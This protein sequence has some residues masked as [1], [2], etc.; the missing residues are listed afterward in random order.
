MSF[1]EIF[2]SDWVRLVFIPLFIV[3]A[4]IVDV[5]LGTLRIIFVSKGMKYLAPALGFV[6]VIIWLFAIGQIMQNLSN[7][8]NYI[9]YGLGF[10]LGN[11]LGIRIEEKLAMGYVML[12]VI[13]RKSA[14]ELK[15]YFMSSGYKFT[16][17]DA[18]SDEGAVNVIYMSVKRKNLHEMITNIKRYNPQAFYTIED[19]KTVSGDVL[20]EKRRSGGVEIAKRK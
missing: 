13:T 7:V 19:V 15:D 10:A 17:V 16:M 6:E 4:R 18:I 8:V 2:D 1:A 11:Y 20:S 12:R 14:H 3:L 9:A 5:S